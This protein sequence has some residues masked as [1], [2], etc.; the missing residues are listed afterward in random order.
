MTELHRGKKKER[1]NQDRV[2][3]IAIA[4]VGNFSRVVCSTLYGSRLVPTYLPTECRRKTIH[5]MVQV[6]HI[7]RV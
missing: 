5:L 7:S 3:E 2:R 6:E 1:E 4:Q